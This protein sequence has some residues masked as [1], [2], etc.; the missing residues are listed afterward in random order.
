MG[1]GAANR[2]SLGSRVHSQIRDLH[3]NKVLNLQSTQSTTCRLGCSDSGNPTFSLEHVG[4]R[5]SP[6]PTYM[7]GTLMRCAT[8][9]KTLTLNPSPGEGEGL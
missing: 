3:N 7:S 6:N 5:L 4:L 2:Q 8:F 1:S 9:P